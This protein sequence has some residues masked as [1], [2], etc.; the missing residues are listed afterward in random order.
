VTW[1][2]RLSNFIYKKN[3]K[4]LFSTNLILKIKMKK[5]KRKQNSF[6]SLK[7]INMDCNWENNNVF[8]RGKVMGKGG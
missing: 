3:Y 5:N 2:M 4:I 6:Q 8:L 7:I 1:V